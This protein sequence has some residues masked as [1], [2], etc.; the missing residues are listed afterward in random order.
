MNEAVEEITIT[1][2]KYQLEQTADYINV[3]SKQLNLKN[4]VLKSVLFCRFMPKI[5]K[6]RLRFLY[7][8]IYKPKPRKYVLCLMRNIGSCLCVVKNYNVNHFSWLL[9]LLTRETSFHKERQCLFKIS[10][11]YIKY[12]IKFIA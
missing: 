3:V 2:G 1:N 6:R 5:N 7:L 12:S 8:I 4:L 9:N 10:R 11:Q